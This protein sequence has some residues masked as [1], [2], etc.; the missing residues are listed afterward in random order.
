MSP[1]QLYVHHA[2]LGGDVRTFARQYRIPLGVALR[3]EAACIRAGWIKMVPRP[4]GSGYKHV[5]QAIGAL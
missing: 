2:A 1:L 4:T 5:E 3:L